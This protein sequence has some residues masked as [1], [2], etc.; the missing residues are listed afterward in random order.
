[1]TTTMLSV[2]L[3]II[4]ANRVQDLR[5]TNAHHVHQLHPLEFPLPTE[6]ANVHVKADIMMIIILRIV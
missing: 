4:H 6:V 1:M 2:P 3:A 5:L